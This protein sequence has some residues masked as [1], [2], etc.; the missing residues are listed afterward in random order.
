MKIYTTIGA[1]SA[2]ICPQNLTSF[3]PWS[4]HQS[5]RN[6]FVRL[7]LA[8]PLPLC[9][10]FLRLSFG[11]YDKNHQKNHKYDESVTIGVID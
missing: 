11:F 2:K 3:W 4:G 9:D 6:F 7:H 1:L 10:R 5:W 8:N